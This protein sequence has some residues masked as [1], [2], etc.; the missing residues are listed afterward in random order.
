MELRRILKVSVI[1]LTCL[2]IIGCSNKKELTDH[3]FREKAENLNFEVT[4]IS[5][6][7]DK[8]TTKKAFLAS[9]T[10]FSVEYYIAKDEKS[11]DIIFDLK[12]NEFA[13]YENKVYESGFEVTKDAGNDYYKY[14]L[15]TDEFYSII[16][17]IKNSVMYG[18]TKPDNKKE[19][20]MFFKEMGY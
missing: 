11:S 2:L 10:N 12:K 7:T 18:Y 3:E 16:S 8:T 13:K 15:K 20:D 19:M 6:H 5:N 9:S 1:L 4:N 17:K 14:T